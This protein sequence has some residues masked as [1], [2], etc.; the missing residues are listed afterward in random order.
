MKHLLAIALVFLLPVAAL[1]A[2]SNQEQEKQATDSATAW[3]TT[4]DAANYE[5]AWSDAG[6]QI[7]RARQ[8]DWIAATKAMREPLGTVVLRHPGGVV[9]TKSVAGL[10]RG[11]YALV[12]F[13]TAFEN[14]AE[15]TEKLTM[16][17][18]GGAWKVAAYTAK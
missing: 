12:F 4:V 1:A 10:S 17:R 11:D 13:S 15:G 8:A 2:D 16:V 7:R 9:L 6:R 3:L 5:Q 14:S 18:E